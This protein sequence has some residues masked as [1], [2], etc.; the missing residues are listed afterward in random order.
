MPLPMPRFVIC[1]PIHISSAQPAV[2][3]SMM[4]TSR[5]EFTFGSALCR[6]KRNA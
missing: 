5:P 3:V 2:S 1:S 6:L 4:I